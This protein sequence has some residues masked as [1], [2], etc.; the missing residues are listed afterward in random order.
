MTGGDIARRTL[1]RSGPRCTH[2]VRGR[3]PSWAPVE[4]WAAVHA[5]GAWTGARFVEVKRAAH[6]SPG[7]RRVAQRS[8]WLRHRSRC[9]GRGE[10]AY[11]ARRRVP[12][13]LAP[14]ALGPVPDPTGR[15]GRGADRALAGLGDKTGVQT[16]QPD[17]A[18]DRRG[19]VE[20][21]HRKQSR[22]ERAR[23]SPE[24]LAHVLDEC[25]HVALAGST[26]CVE[27]AWVHRR[28]AVVLVSDVGR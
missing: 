4:F 26:I 23:L 13:A 24:D 9:R 21:G 22:H 15:D 16:S 3:R 25:R 11:Q 1:D 28:T 5:A 10:I 27:G 12:A 17:V 18:D 14:R 6:S 2:L 20:K 19:H 8:A 7:C